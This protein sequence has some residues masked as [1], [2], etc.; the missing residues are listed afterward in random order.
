MKKYSLWLLLV[1]GYANPVL[2]SLREH[3]ETAADIYNAFKTNIAAAG[4]ELSEKAADT[5]LDEAEKLLAQ[6][7]SRGITVIPFEDDLYPDALSDVPNP[8][9]V[10][11]AKG[12]TALLKNKLVTIGGSRKATQYTI[13]AETHVCEELCGK[14]T[15]V[16]SLVEGCEQLACI[17]A[18]KMGK[19]C[20]EILPCGFDHEYPKG[21]H[22][23]REQVLMNGGCIITEFLPDV[24]SCNANFIRRARIAG[25]ISKAMIIFQAR[26]NSG[27]FNTAKYS[28]ALFFLPIHDVFSYKYAGAVQYIRNGAGIYYSIED[29]DN[30]FKEGFSAPEISIK[31]IIAEQKKAEKPTAA[32]KKAEEKAP[33][34]SIEPSGELFETPVHYSVYKKISALDSPITFDELFR[35]EDIGI[36]ELSEILLDL[37]IAALIKAVPGSRYTVC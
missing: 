28:P 15:L 25:G 10:L 3:F 20:I 6:L 16:A 17:T 11:F 29:I 12:N 2:S 35:N 32:E 14:Y 21:S 24:K 27:A 1:F 30:A 5:S 31:D 13:A 36:T 22:V 19:G 18:M 33:A 26:I 34:E 23:L 7:E 8:P 9:C 4:A 37:E